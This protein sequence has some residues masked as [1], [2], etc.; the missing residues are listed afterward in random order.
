MT[1]RRL[2]RALL[3]FALAGAAVA[4]YLTWV[5]YA[6]LEPICAGGGGG[7]ERVQNSDYAE[8]A[9][10]PI[11][12]VGLLGYVAILGS[13]A[14]PGEA[15]RL[16]VAFLALVG[17]GFSAYLTYLELFVIN[18]ICQWCVVSA[19]IMGL[20]LGLA[21]TRLLSA[22]ASEARRVRS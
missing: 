2:G 21:V 6:G 12:V 4:G 1:D 17:A 5:H 20:L 7:C 8:L 13:L 22:S 14:L 9:G 16:S 18:A 3:V 10:V 19:V 11:A 15:G